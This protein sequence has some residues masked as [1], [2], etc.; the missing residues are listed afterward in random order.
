MRPRV[1]DNQ[2]EKSVAL[3]ALENR[4]TSYEE[5]KENTPLIFEE[6]NNASR[7]NNL[8]A[9]KLLGGLFKRIRELKDMQTLVLCRKITNI[10]VED[11]FVKI[12]AEDSALD[13]LMESVHSK[14][15][16]EEYFKSIGFGVKFGNRS[17]DNGDLE[18]L[19]DLL[20]DALIIK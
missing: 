4:E 1:N 11:S 5:I 6:K 19:K 7:E 14:N 2:N 16:I 20:G 15:A 12:D 17:L 13:I 10:T 18:K 3:G 9:E 8:T